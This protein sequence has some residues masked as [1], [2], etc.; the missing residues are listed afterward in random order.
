MRICMR[1][2]LSAYL[3]EGVSS[4]FETAPRRIDRPCQPRMKG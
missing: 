4:G 2:P 1:L 3:R